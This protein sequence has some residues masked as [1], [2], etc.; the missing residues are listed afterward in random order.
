MHTHLDGQLPTYNFRRVYEASNS[1]IVEDFYLPALHRAIKYDR[2]AGYFRSSV[3]HLTH[4]AMTD[5]IL[6]N[7]TMRLICSTS[8]TD[9]DEHVIR[10]SHIDPERIDKSITTDIS[11]ALRDPKTST[12]IEL[13][14]TMVETG[15]LEV[16]VAYKSDQSGIF[17]TKVGIFMDK[18]DNAL[19]FEGS[20]NE[21]FMA[22][23]HN[24]ERFKAFKS[25]E[26]GEDSHVL[27]DQR[28]FQDLWEGKRHSLVVRPL[29]QIARDI[30]RVHANPDPQAAVEKVRLTQTR[31]KHI[32]YKPK[33]LHDHQL[34]IYEA[35]K[36]QPAGLVNHATGSGKTITA[37][38]CA[39]EW[40]TSQA[41]ASLVIVVPSD[42][43]TTQWREEVNR[44][45]FNLNPQILHVGGAHSRRDWRNHIRHFT[46][47]R[48]SNRPRVV[49]ATMDSASKNDFTEKAS[50]G[51]HT[52]MIVDEVHKVGSL[53]R[54]KILTLN[55]GSRLGL[56]ATPSRFGDEE[57]TSAINNFF[58]TSYLPKFTIADAQNTQPPRLVQYNYHV[59]IVCLQAEEYQE[60]RRLSR[61]IGALINAADRD[62][63]D[64]TANLTSTLIKRAKVLKKAADKIPH[65]VNLLTDHYQR[66]Q[67]WLV[68]CDDT[69]QLSSLQALL[70]EADIPTTHY[71]A[72]M[73]SSKPETIERFE[74][75]GGVLLSIRCLDEGIDIPNIS[76][77]LILSSSL[78]PREHIQRRG[79]VL[80]TA[81]GKVDATIYDTLVGASTDQEGMRVFDHEVDRAMAFAQDARN[82]RQALW[83]IDNLPRE[84]TADWYNLELDDRSIADG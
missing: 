82:R 6:R 57:G 33:E 25:W 77:A 74:E 64:A 45:L 39:R 48:D 29:P 3:F 31:S 55:P 26:P 75:I 68:Y 20:P 37:L 10:N 12:V 73:E 49:I 24:E 23:Q 40:L 51:N 53:T 60:Y 2:A 80:R 78:N 42:L 71:L 79:R 34:Q 22:W 63:P 61:I 19:S 35:W 59:G 58:Q 43:L 46:Q 17:H 44:E 9:E 7:G 41:K 15:T 67:R 76:H 27:D 47:D 66:G 54:R 50:V 56:S 30:L 4:L 83:H 14:A 65:A 13:L 28:Y 52:L 16:R 8:L 69:Q 81:P 36:Q 21:T 84:V 72:S 5:F 18:E 62:E 38:A 11:K 32:R 70:Q 1:D